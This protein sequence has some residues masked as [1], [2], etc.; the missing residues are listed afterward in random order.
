M[1]ERDVASI[2]LSR[3]NFDRSQAVDVDTKNKLGSA[4]LQ[5]CIQRRWVEA[6]EIVGLVVSSRPSILGEIQRAVLSQPLANMPLPVNMPRQEGRRNLTLNHAAVC[7]P[8]LAPAP[9]A[10]PSELTGINE[11]AALGWQFSGGL[12]IIN[13]GLRCV[14]EA[15]EV[16]EDYNVGDEVVVAEDGQVYT[17]VVQ[18]KKQ[19]GFVLSFGQKKPKTVKPSYSKNELS[20]SAQ[21]SRPAPVGPPPGYA[22]GSAAAPVAPAVS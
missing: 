4:G 12:G 13:K 22:V 14:L 21:A 10:P 5:F 2:L 7:T 11:S 16:P 8:S 6:D 3:K 17:A 15:A 18:A 9:P 19:D 1:T 20:R